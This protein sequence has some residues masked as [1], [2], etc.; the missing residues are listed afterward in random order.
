MVGHSNFLKK[1]MHVITLIGWVTKKK[2]AKLSD[3]IF[4]Q[5]S[6]SKKMPAFDSS[7]GFAVRHSPDGSWGFAPGIQVSS[8]HIIHGS[9]TLKSP[10]I[11]RWTSQHL[12]H[13]HPPP[14]KKK[15]KTQTKPTNMAPNHDDFTSSSWVHLP[16]CNQI[17]S[18]NGIQELMDLA[19][20]PQLNGFLLYQQKQRLGYVKYMLDGSALQG[21]HQWFLGRQW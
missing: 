4:T 2:L 16:V 10:R 20:G 6:L 17:S 9:S 11:K 7:F 14:H 12:Y 18:R 3:W 19:P 21:K 5:S 13:Q 15:E 1:G 8:G